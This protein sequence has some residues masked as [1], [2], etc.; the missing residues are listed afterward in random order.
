MA[1]LNDYVSFTCTWKI[2]NFCHFPLMKYGVKSPPF[3]TKPAGV[4]KWMLELSFVPD[5]KEFY[6]LVLK[7]QSFLSERRSIKCECELSFLASDG[8]S[9]RHH[10][11]FHADQG[12]PF[13]F[14]CSHYIVPKS[15][16]HSDERDVF[17]PQDTLTIRCRIWHLGLQS[18]QCFFCTNI[19]SESFF[20]NIQ[21]LSRVQRVTRNNFLLASFQFRVELQRDEEGTTY[22]NTIIK[23]RK[24]NGWCNLSITLGYHILKDSE[25]IHVP[26]LWTEF[27]NVSDIINQQILADDTLE[28]KWTFTAVI[29]ETS[30][31]AVQAIPVPITCTNNITSC[32]IESIRVPAN[33]LQEFMLL[34]YRGEKFSDATLSA[35]G[36]SFPI[37]RAVLASRSPVFS[38]MFEG[39]NK[40]SQ[41]GKPIL[42]F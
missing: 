32:Y 11:V 7:Q 8:T 38:A 15:E 40:E 42:S 13:P 41:A 25:N 5:N 26:D 27:A 6:Q 37:H 29:N 19:R 34:L 33:S 14:I 10:K 20:W 12:S 1:F 31:Q 4:A 17:L 21:Q 9:L 3:Q 2:K 22:V 28:I 30:S 35:D 23:K 24:Y 39:N 16:M 18:D 36:A